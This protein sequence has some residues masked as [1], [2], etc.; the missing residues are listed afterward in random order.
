[1]QAKIVSNAGDDRIIELVDGVQVTLKFIDDPGSIA[2][3]SP[4]S[5]LIGEFE[6]EEQDGGNLHIMRAYLEAC[7]GRFKRKGIGREI[8]RYA[9]D[10]YGLPITATPGD[11]VER[12]DGSH[13]TQDAPGFISRMM[14]EGFVIDHRE[15]YDDEGW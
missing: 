6:F 3:Y 13:L 11:G 10:I 15:K 1:M 5:E 4:E 7:D 2:A 14:D 8:L 12:S 9:H